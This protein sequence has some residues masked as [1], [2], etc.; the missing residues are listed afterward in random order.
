MSFWYFTVWSLYPTN[1]NL[2][3]TAYSDILDNSVLLNLWQQF[4]FCHFLF[5]HD[6]ASIQK[7]SSRR[8]CFTQ[9][10]MEEL[11]LTS[12]LSN[13][14]GMD[15]NTNCEPGLSCKHHVPESVESSVVKFEQI[16]DPEDILSQSDSY[17]K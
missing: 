2:N 8:K 15:W 12:T 3:A 16:K 17:Y 10:G 13:A 14:F 4:G 9:F 5:Q 11:D 7:A 6:N 1:A